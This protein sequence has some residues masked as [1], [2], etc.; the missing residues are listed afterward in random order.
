[1]LSN[2]AQNFIKIYL[3]SANKKNKIIRN[4][5]KYIQCDPLRLRNK[6]SSTEKN[7]DLECF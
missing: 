3:M 4:L 5:R 6:K 1:M 7:L 2:S